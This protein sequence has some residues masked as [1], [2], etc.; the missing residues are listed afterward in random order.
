MAIDITKWRAERE[1]RRRNTARQELVKL[2][3]TSL[4]APSVNRLQLEDPAYSP[5]NPSF[6]RLWLVRFCPNLLSPRVPCRRRPRSCTRWI[7]SGLLLIHTP[8]KQTGRRMLY[9]LLLNGQKS[10]IDFITA[11]AESV[12]PSQNGDPRLSKMEACRRSCRR[13]RSGEQSL[14]FDPH[15]CNPLSSFTLNEFQKW[16]LSLSL[17]SRPAYV[18]P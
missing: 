4:T 12:P 16:G 7:R 3:N 11:E 6:H 18:K 8:R 15:C 5:Y 1:G 9:Y 17:T 2:V 10:L 13:G 14:N